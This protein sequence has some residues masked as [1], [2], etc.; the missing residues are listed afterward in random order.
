MIL[1]HFIPLTVGFFLDLLIGDPHFLPHPVRLMGKAIELGEE[2]MRKLFPDTER[3]LLA[4][5]AVLGILIPL[6]TGAVSGGILL[7]AY[8]LNLWLG[9]FL[10]TIMCYQILAV[11]SLKKESMKV[12][13]ELKRGDLAGAREKVSMIV[14]R[15]TEHLNEEQVAKAAV[16]TVAENT[17]DGT[18][19]PML[20]MAVGGAPLGFF[21][22]AVNTL[23]SMVGYKND[24]YLFFGRFSAKLDDVLNFIPARISAL[25]MVIASMLLGMDW[26]GAYRIF[27][28]D[29]FNHASPNSAQ[30]EAVC[31]GALGI[32]LA[33]DAWY[34]GKL[35]P[36]KTIGDGTR[37]VSWEDIRSANRLLYGT[38]FLCLGVCLVIGAIMILIM[39][40]VG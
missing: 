19:A 36:K 1:L 23:D 33:G 24:R 34:F 27:R 30:T 21:Y 39:M 6:L 26:R 31:A 12:F 29:R 38:A 37:P 9:L 4:A 22:K 18:V 11:K 7:A 32:R 35:Y 15:D 16:E 17:S 10:E 5:G 2:L 28:R 8:R 13:D 25:L 40:G 14:G 3:G 20:F